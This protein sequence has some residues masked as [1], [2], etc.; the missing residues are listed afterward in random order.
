MSFLVHIEAVPK[1]GY[2]NPAEP[3]EV[4]TTSAICKSLSEEMFS[5]H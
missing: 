1:A 5:G 4:I 2:S 3:C